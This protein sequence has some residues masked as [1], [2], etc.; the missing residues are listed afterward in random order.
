[1]HTISNEGFPVH[2]YPAE[3]GNLYIKYTVRFPRSLSEQQKEGIKS[4]LG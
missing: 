2:N 4:L 1:V 3:K